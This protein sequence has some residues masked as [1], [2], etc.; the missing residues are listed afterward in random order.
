MRAWGKT[1]IGLV[2]SENQDAFCVDLMQD[3]GVAICVVCDGMG[4][5]NAGGVASIIAA[6]AFSDTVRDGITGDMP[7]Q[8]AEELV[9]TAARRANEEVWRHA[10]ANP[11]CDGMGTTLVAAIVREQRDGLSRAIIA[12]I[13]D[14][15]A[16]LAAGNGIRRLTRDHSIV[17]DLITS[18][19][20]T[21]EQAKTHP[22]KNV[23]TRALGT[24]G[25][26][27]CDIYRQELHHG[28]L[29]LLCSDGLSNMVEE[30]EMLYETMHGGER[31]NACRRLID[32]ANSRGGR[33]NITAVLYEA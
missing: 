25:E 33:D 31:E 12:N 5:A 24:L 3:E 20:L 8:T 29:L 14:S 28:E 1:D 26:V 6:R 19:S 2:R 32:I 4:G 16:Y 10:E 23:I 9:R 18:G 17:E 7:S 22:E 30:Q 21:R 27:E 13:G 11:E 15:R